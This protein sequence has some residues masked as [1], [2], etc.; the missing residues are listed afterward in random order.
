MVLPHKNG[1]TIYN[2][3]TNKFSVTLMDSG[4]LKLMEREYIVTVHAGVDLDST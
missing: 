1:D 2:T 4:R 3:D